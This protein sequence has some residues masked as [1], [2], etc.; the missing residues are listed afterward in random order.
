MAKNGFNVEAALQAAGVN[1]SAAKAAVDALDAQFGGEAGDIPEGVLDRWATEHFPSRSVRAFLIA[2]GRAWEND[3]ELP[4]DRQWEK[5]PDAQA[6][7][8]RR[9]EAKAAKK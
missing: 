8:R 2:L 5:G 1:V 4:K 7:K 6:E 3:I 9:N